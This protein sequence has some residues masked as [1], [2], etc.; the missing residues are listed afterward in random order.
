M[1]K[2][3]LS[4]WWL[5]MLPAFNLWAAPGAVRLD[6]ATTTV[7]LNTAF[8][9]KMLVDS[10]TKKVG[11][12]G[13]KITYDATKLKVNTATATSAITTGTNALSSNI[14]NADVPGTLKVTGFHAQG[15][16][17]GAAL[18]LITANFQCLAVAGTYPV[19]LV[20]EMLTDEGGFTI[21]TPTAAGSTVSCGNVPTTKPDFVITS[22][23][24]PKTGTPVPVVNGTF[25]AAITVKN[26]GTAAGDG[27]T[28]SVWNHGIT[29]PACPAAGWS[30]QAAVGILAVNAST[31][32]TI[33]GIPSGALAGT[34]LLR[35]F[36]DSACA[37]VET[38]ETNN[39]KYL[40][41]PVNKT[42]GADL[43]ITGITLTPPNSG[44][45]GNFSATIVV[46]NQG[47]IASVAGTLGVWNHRT[48]AAYCGAAPTK[49]VAIPSIAVG[50]TKS[51]T[52]AGIPA[53]ATAGMK[54][55]RAYVDNGCTT[56][57][58]NEAN[59]QREAA[60]AVS[61]SAPAADFSITAVTLN[62]VSPTANTAFS[63]TIVIKNNSTTAGDGRFL[64]AW[65]HNPGLPQ[66]CG[67]IGNKRIAVGSI[68]ANATVTKI[69]T[70]LVGGPGATGT[71]SLRLYVD[72]ACG[73]NE[74]NEGNNQ[75]VKTY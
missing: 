27:K 72:S 20:V 8:G 13:V 62:P 69:I 42:P 35:A 5:G 44:M 21:G 16:G 43:T 15:V 38:N 64:D 67:A 22:I 59:N 51:F 17:P 73:T 66:Y 71:R 75:F 68:P 40:D 70:G 28:L 52:V 45:N 50:V 1:K 74:I 32:I 19:T 39:Q 56:A 41:Y 24:V 49:Q 47:T 33:A 12:Y 18:H 46:K 58:T 34:K 7:A 31:T 3:L 61:A 10:G 54:R 63:A 29:V 60:Y 11:T 65:S 30:K 57:E 37:T 6:P 25:T 9:L 14:Y 55:L 4:W 36:V 48:E 53:G 23:Q 26:Q 2:L